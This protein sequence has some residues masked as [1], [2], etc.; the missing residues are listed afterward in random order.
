MQQP[1]RHAPRY[2]PRV[3]GTVTGGEGKNRMPEYFVVRTDKD[4]REWILSEIRAGRL[5]QGW[6][7]KKQTSLVSKTGDTVAESVWIASFRAGVPTNAQKRCRT[8]SFAPEKYRELKQMLGIPEGARIIVPKLDADGGEDGFVLARAARAPGGKRP[9]RGCYWFDQN[10]TRRDD[11][12]HVVAVDPESVRTIPSKDSRQIHEGLKALRKPVNR[13][14]R[15]GFNETIERLYMSLSPPTDTSPLKPGSAAEEQQARKKIQTDISQRQ[16]QA[17]FRQ[18]VLDAYGHCCAISDCDEDAALEAA[19]IR[20][21]KGSD[22]NHIRNG[23]LLRSDIHTLFD[24]GL[25]RVRTATC[26]VVIDDKLKSTCYESLDGKSVR[27]PT[28]AKLWH[29]ALDYHRQKKVFP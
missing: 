16:G 29:N 22:V 12:R 15:E 27:L 2:G 17:K 4:S 26:T 8:P 14:I 25:I 28:N 1:A 20:T 9:A 23:I 11:F 18:E 19:H 6:F 7:A 5:R 21:Y 10:E 3:S 13:S 24:L